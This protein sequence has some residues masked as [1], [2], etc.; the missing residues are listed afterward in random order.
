[1]VSSALSP[2]HGSRRC[3]ADY[4]VLTALSLFGLALGV[5]DNLA[6]RN[7]SRGVAVIFAPWTAAKDVVARAVAPGARFVGFGGARFVAIVI[8]DNADYVARANKTG[9]WLVA[10]PRTLPGCGDAVRGI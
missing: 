3:I 4:A 1:L 5:Q 9:A 2:V 8:P 10:D 6:P 7:P